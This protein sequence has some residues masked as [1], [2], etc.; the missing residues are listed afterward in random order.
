MCK[1]GG[2]D[3]CCG[4]KGASNHA[5][6]I[7]GYE[8]DR[9]HSGLRRITRRELL[10]AAGAT[11]LTLGLSPIVG[12]LAGN[13]AL[14]QE[15]GESTAVQRG[16]AKHLTILQTTDIHAQLNTH[17][18]FFWE[19]D[20]AVYR[21]RGGLSRIKSLVESVRRQNPEGTLLADTGDC[22]Q[23]G[24][25]AALSQGEAMVPLMNYMSYD[26]VLP[27]NWEVVY[28]KDQLL[29]VAG[30]YDAPVVCTNMFHDV[31][32]SPGKLLFL[33]YYATEVLGVKI[34]FIGYNDPLVP[35]R[36][37]PSYSEGIQFTFPETNIAEYIRVLREQE[38][39]DLVFVMTHMGLA[40]QVHLANQS[41]TE[42][43][44]YILG[45]D[46]HERVREP[47]QGTHARVTEPGAFG[48]FVGRLDLV[49]EN[50]KIKEQGYQ[51]MEVDP[52][53]YPE[54]REMQRRVNSARKPYKAEIERVLG[55]T[56][57]PLVRY[58]VLETPMDNL[59]TD[60][61]RWKVGTDVALS[62]GFRF[63]P[64]LVPDSSGKADVTKEYLWSMLPVNSNVRTGQVTG[65]QILDWWEN[66]LENVFAPDPTRRFG[67]WVARC[68][69][70]EMNF[71]SS[72][73][74]GS[75]V[76]SV[77]IGGLDLAPSANYTIAACE[78]EGD[79]V[80]TLCRMPN[81]QN[82]ETKDFT[83][84]D[85]IDEYLKLRSPVAP[86]VEGRVTAT[87]QPQTLLSQ[88]PGTGYEFR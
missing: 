87:D 49:V 61:L 27:G 72:E 43:T 62:N 37:S 13:E 71:T 44:D 54:E 36:Q 11:G 77:K 67:G 30:E 34:G 3:E 33:P 85:V 41:Y 83:L 80:T 38:A 46:T 63:C 73:P 22:F 48:S 9:G 64:P 32:G 52:E 20:R 88:L 18:E 42:G 81:A 35:K 39:C 79:P 60:T 2:R 84:H 17:D 59:I 29:K 14:A 26:L 1:A 21:K 28:G 40:Q 4:L 10:R 56:A 51:L 82:P 24:A 16:A 66:E 6:K 12:G 25:V 53:K 57:T 8:E 75:R 55:Q 70:M 47:L 31:N 69:G 50:G 58:F 7:V 15:A 86:E 76:N 74:R 45:A 19:N 23:G 65:Q 68:S 5:K 78:R